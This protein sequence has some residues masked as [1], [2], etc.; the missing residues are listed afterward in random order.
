MLAYQK[1]RMIIIDT[2]LVFIIGSFL[3]SRLFH[4]TQMKLIVEFKKVP[5]ISS[6]FFFDRMD[7]HYRGIDVGDVTKIKLSDEHQ[8]YRWVPFRQLSNSDYEHETHFKAAILAHGRL[9]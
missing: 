6:K 2:I 9:K 7:V 3:V 5:P 4:K 1:K 8:H